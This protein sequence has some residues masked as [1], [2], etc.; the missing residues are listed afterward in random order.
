[1]DAT[2]LPVTSA[3]PRGHIALW[4]EATGELRAREPRKRESALTVPREVS[5]AA[6]VALGKAAG[7]PSA[8]LPKAS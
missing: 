2:L 1:M 3:A 6:R 5:S 4:F 7:T 8:S